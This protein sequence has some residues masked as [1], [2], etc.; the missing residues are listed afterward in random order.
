MFDEAFDVQIRKK[1][2]QATATNLI[3]VDSFGEKDW[4]SLE[5]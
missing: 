2:L 1:T 4:R 3:H 5:V